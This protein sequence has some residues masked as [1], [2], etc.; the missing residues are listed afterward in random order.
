MNEHPITY[1]ISVTDDDI[2]L[3][4][5]AIQA[6]NQQPTQ[7]SHQLEAVSKGRQII[8]NWLA[9]HAIEISDELGE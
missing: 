5:I 6:L 4:V 8:R 9:A 7:D 2:E 1:Q 3:L